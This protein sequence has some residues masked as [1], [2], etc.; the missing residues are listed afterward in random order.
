MQ[1]YLYWLYTELMLGQKVL[2]VED[3]PSLSQVIKYNL[4]KNGYDVLISPDGAMALEKTLNMRPDII[5]LDIMLPGLDGLEVCRILKSE[6]DIPIIMLTARSEE[7][8][9]VLGLEIGA[10]DYIT[11]PFSMRELL[12]RIKAVLRRQSNF[13][14]KQGKDQLPQGKTIMLSGIKIDTT[15]HQVIHNGTLLELT[16]KEFDLLLFLMSNPERVFSRDYLL[17]RVW[18]YDYAGDTRTVDVHICW[19]REKIETEP[20]KPVHLLTVRGVGYKFEA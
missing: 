5:I 11:K 2:L 19:L 16:P 14:E 12:A 20:A 13:K 18:G 4:V 9:K 7:M 10:D 1:R 8:D 17:E 6:T 3:D 15:R